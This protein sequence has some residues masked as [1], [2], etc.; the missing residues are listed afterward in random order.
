MSQSAT[1]FTFV[2]DEVVF[3]VGAFE[4]A[5]LAWQLGSG[6]RTQKA[7]VLSGGR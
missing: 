2:P 6:L 1:L 3:D 4:T 7:R 5:G